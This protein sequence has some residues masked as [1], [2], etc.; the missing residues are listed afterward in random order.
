MF[1]KIYYQLRH[2]IIPSFLSGVAAAIFG[3]IVFASGALF[4][5]YLAAVTS[6]LCGSPNYS[7]GQAR[8]IGLAC[9]VSGFISLC[10]AVVIIKIS[11]FFRWTWHEARGRFVLDISTHRHLLE[12]I[13]RGEDFWCSKNGILWD[14]TYDHQDSLVPV[15]K[16]FINKKNGKIVME[17]KND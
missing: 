2:R 14:R 1:R 15:K 17:R 7:L 4:F 6:H 9:L 5:G 11:L 12:A 13:D 8:L 10:I 16:L 3:A